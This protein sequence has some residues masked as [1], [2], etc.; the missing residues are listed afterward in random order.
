MRRFFL[1]VALAAI[2]SPAAAQPAPWSAERMTAGWVFTPAFVFGGMWDTNVTVRNEGVPETAELVG[3]VNPR[4]EIDFNGKRTKF[5]AGYSGAL[6]TYRNLDE[7]TRYDQRGRVDSRYQMTP[8]LLFQTRNQL[9]LTPTTDQLDV[10]GSL[11]FTRVGSRMLTSVNGF[12]F[13]VSRRMALTATYNFQWVTFDR[14]SAEPDFQFLRGGH[15]HSPSAE[16]TYA[17]SRRVKIGALYEYRHTDIDAG[18]EIF[19]TNRLLATVEY[20]LGPETKLTGRGGVDHLATSDVGESR[21]GPSYGAGVSHRVR[22]AIFD[23]NYER[24]FVP[25][26]GFGGMT[27][28]H[29]AHVGAQM[30]F[31]QGRLIW[32]AGFT[33]RR[34]DPLESRGLNIRLDSYYGTS[35]LGYAIARWLRMEGFYSLTHQFSDARGNVDRTRIGIQFVTSKPMRIQ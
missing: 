4:G 22:L 19:D 5:S 14:S 17:L 35:T 7:L 29:V 1:I 32:T 20:H 25:S 6:E 13:D 12:T 15:A 28:N 9:T 23:A 3:I 18:E 16:L 26:F 24:L 27:A 10:E 11:P 30:P 8:R 31:M 34:T 2:A 33:Y 21:T